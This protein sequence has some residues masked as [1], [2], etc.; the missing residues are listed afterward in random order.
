MRR[1]FKLFFVVVS[2]FI[3]LGCDKKEQEE[4]KIGAI[5]CLTGPGAIYGEQDKMGMDLGVELINKSGGINGKTV[6]IIYEDSKTDPSEGVLAAQKLIKTNKVNIIIGALASSVSLAIA[7]IANKNKVIMISP[8]SSNPQLSNA[9]EYIFR[10]YPSDDYQGKVL[11][12][13]AIDKMNCNKIAVLYV[14]NDF[15]IG[16]KN[17]FIEV[18]NKKGGDIII[19]E[20]YN[21][22]DIDVRA[23]ITKIQNK[24][25]EALL[26]AS[27]GREYLNILR[28]LKELNVNSKLLAPDSFYNEDI[29]KQ[30]RE[31]AEGI[32]CTVPSFNLESPD[33]ITQNFVKEFKKKYNKKPSS[34]S[35][36]GFD[37]IMLVAEVLEDV[38]YNNTEKIKDKLYKIKFN[39]AIGEIKFDKNGDVLKELDIYKVEKGNF[40]KISNQYDK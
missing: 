17:K 26:I 38:P 25:P 35:A 22:E 8:G 15:G 10:I 31:A 3:I 23:Q 5:L 6:N 13:I 34:F 29:I 9:G 37:A 19:S 40:I 4:I 2:I 1:F 30:A 16:L 32:I 18:I 7:P 27:Q 11:A 28:Q 20:A 24:K 36:Y 12:N 14:N 21:P 33:S 39:G